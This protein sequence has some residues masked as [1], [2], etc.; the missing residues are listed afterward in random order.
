MTYLESFLYYDIDIVRAIED[1]LIPYLN[2]FQSHNH[3][4]MKSTFNVF[5]SILYILASLIALICSPNVRISTAYSFIRI[6]EENM[7]IHLT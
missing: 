6:I 4:L 2:L 3:A 1:E 7:I 5:S